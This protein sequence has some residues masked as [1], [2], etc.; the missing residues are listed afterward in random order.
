MEEQIKNKIL[1]LSFNKQLLFGLSCVKRMESHLENYLA[2]NGKTSNS[3]AIGKLIDKI[4]LSCNSDIF[5]RIKELIDDDDIDL[6]KQMIPDSEEDGSVEAVLA[7]NAAIALAYCLN[8]TKDHN[9]DFINY[10]G[11]KTVE[12]TDVIALGL[13]QLE[14]SDLLISEELT[15]QSQILEAIDNMRRDFDR[16]DIEEFKQIITK[17]KIG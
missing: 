16:E 11:Q 7:Q 17:L 14:S 2:I 4:L 6:V 13:Q 12:T 15:I 8:F 9:S 1:K 5:Y 3:V 10:C